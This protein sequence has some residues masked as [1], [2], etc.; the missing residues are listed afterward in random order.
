[1]ARLVNSLNVHHGLDSHDAALATGRSAAQCVRKYREWKAERLRDFFASATGATVE[2][3]LFPSESLL[4]EKDLVYSPADKGATSCSAC[5]SVRSGRWWTMIQED[6]DGVYCDT[7]HDLFKRY[8]QIPKRLPVE[9]P[10]LSTKAVE[11]Q[12]MEDQESA[13]GP[14]S[15]KQRVR[16]AKR[17][18]LT[19]SRLLILTQSSFLSA[20]TYH[21][22][23]VVVQGVADTASATCPPAAKATA[24]RA[25]QNPRAGQKPSHP[26]LKLRL[27]GSS[28]ML[29]RT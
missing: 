23:K 22:P 3:I 9:L 12:K 4:T 11:K 26:L 6:Y 2:P 25:L 13:G 16:N 15:K 28:V 29:R 10:K 19:R 5:A 24:V 14:P 20:R 21:L 27:L 7:C 8:G 1:M 17:L 18:N